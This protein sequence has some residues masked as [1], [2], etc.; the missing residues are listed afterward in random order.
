MFRIIILPKAQKQIKGIK[1]IYKQAIKLAIE[2][3]K[4]DP[5]VGK[6]LSRELTGK[7]TYKVSVY[8][9]IYKINKEDKIVNILSAGHRS[10][11]YD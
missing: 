2:E 3:I 8:R 6:L 5:F 7:F 10:T 9:I 11:V 1:K 4:D